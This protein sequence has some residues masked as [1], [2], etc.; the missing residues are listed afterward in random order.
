MF[1]N[2]R[3]AGI[4][5]AWLA[6]AAASFSSVVIGGCG[7]ARSPAAS[8]RPAADAPMLAEDRADDAEVSSAVAQTPADALEAFERAAQRLVALSGGRL[9]A[10]AA[11]ATTV[12]GGADAASPASPAPEPRAENAAGEVKTDTDEAPSDATAKHAAREK[13]K[14]RAVGVCTRACEA[15]ASMQRSAVRLCTLAGETE[16]LCIDV[17]GRLEAAR[18]R[19]YAHCPT[20][21]A[22]QPVDE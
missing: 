21:E 1:M 10:T 18:A 16:P 8:P 15:F 17:R 22:A 5:V 2:K 14:R 7:G 19:I 9:F 3:C 13:S 4:R 20:C 11:G 6:F 12:A